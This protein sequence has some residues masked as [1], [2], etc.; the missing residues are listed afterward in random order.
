MDFGMLEFIGETKCSTYTAEP[1]VAYGT[2]IHETSDCSE[3][4]NYWRILSDAR[5]IANALNQRQA[6]SK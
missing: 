5:C 6:T 4:R 2:H 3:S 1:S